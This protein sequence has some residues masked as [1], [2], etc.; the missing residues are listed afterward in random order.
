MHLHEAL[1]THPAANV[2]GLPWRTLLR[3]I[4]KGELKATKLGQT[5]LIDP[6][7]LRDFM[8]RYPDL[9]KGGRPRK[10]P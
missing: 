6:A 9:S 2:C 3:W 7:D 5:Y 10:R 1:R 4:S 8:V